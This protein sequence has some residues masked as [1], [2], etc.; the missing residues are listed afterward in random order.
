MD[1]PT[2]GLHMADTERLLGIIDRLVEMGNTVIVIEHNLDVMAAADWII[3]M[4]PGGGK[5]G[6]EV[7]AAGTPEEV[8]LSERSLTGRCLAAAL[9][10]P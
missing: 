8:A 6:G 2:S 10:R 3:D 7:V 5:L 1:E 9:R 4:G